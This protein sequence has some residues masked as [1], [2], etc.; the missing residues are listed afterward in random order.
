[1]H[2][3]TNYIAIQQEDFQVQALHDWL[4]QNNTRDG[5]IVTFVG[6]VRD[7]NQGNKVKGLYLE[8]YPS[9]VEKSLNNI[10]ERARTRWSIGRVC[11]VHRVGELTLNDNIVFV[12]VSAEHRK[13][14]FEACQFVMDYLKSQVPIWKKEQGSDGQYW[15]KPNDTEALEFAK[16]Q[17]PKVSSN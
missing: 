11:V 16:W 1:M 10:I 2:T 17:D 13:T 14:A 3:E 4:S 9:M 7:F 6:L 8:H 12:G 5:A 15:V